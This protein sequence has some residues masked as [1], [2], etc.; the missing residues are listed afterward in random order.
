MKTKSKK[1]KKRKGAPVGGRQAHL[2][3]ETL[4]A[5]QRAAAAARKLAEEYG[6]SATVRSA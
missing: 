5:I 3:L 1:E 4:R 2:D 6:L